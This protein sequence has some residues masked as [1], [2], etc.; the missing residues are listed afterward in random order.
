MEDILL[1]TMYEMP[2]DLMNEK[3]KKITVTQKFV[4]NKSKPFLVF[5]TDSNETNSETEESENQ[6]LLASSE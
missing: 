5:S 1:D 2:S 6:A 3:N 4:E